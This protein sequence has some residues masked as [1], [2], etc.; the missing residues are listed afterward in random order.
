LSELGIWGERIAE[1]YLRSKGYRLIARNYR[2][3][4]GEIDLIF[5]SE[6]ICV[7]VEVKTRSSEAYG[8]PE[9]FVD[10][11][12]QDMIHQCAERFMDERPLIGEI[13]FDIF[14]VLGAK[15]RFKMKHWESAF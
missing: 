2:I 1:N 5:E 6:N 10:E 11:R 13:R 12:K 14:G 9:E 7:F 15:N 8:R 4:R 3:G